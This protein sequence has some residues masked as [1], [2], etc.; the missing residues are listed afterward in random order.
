MQ[1][2]PPAASHV[3]RVRGIE[4]PSAGHSMGHP[5][6]DRSDR[7]HRH[8]DL[9]FW[10]F[11]RSVFANLDAW[12]RGGPPMPYVPRMQRDPN[13][14]DGVA[15]SE[16]RRVGKECR[17]RRSEEHEEKQQLQSA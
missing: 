10:V 14:I 1:A 12:V 13:S 7:G 5:L 6:T 16:E 17:S 2:T 9:P 4:F 11:M 3:P 15:R 8:T